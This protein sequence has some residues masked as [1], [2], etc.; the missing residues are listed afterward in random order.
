M[1]EMGR[2]VLF[3]MMVREGLSEELIFKQNEV[4]KQTLLL[5]EGRAFLVGGRKSVQSL[6]QEY[7]VHV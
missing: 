4:S 1:M 5:S 3:E 2:R 6:R 7:A